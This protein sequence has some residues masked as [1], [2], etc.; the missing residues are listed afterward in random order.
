MPTF[1]LSTQAGSK[2]NVFDYWLI[3][4]Q[5]NL[6]CVKGK[7]A[8]AIGVPD[9]TPIRLHA[10]KIQTFGAEHV[11]HPKR[12]VQIDN[13]LKK[14]ISTASRFK[15]IS[16]SRTQAPEY[17]W[18]KLQQSGSVYSTESDDKSQIVLQR[19]PSGWMFMN[20]SRFNPDDIYLSIVTLYP[21][22]SSNI[23]GKNL[24]RY[25]GQWVNEV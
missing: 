2:V 5:K 4:G 10:G 18:L 25:L 8:K 9:G 13:I 11:Y 14:D 7:V 19:A 24:G 21:K 16:L 22:Q 17:V 3:D 1:S 20:V 15:E 23:D 12:R 6:S